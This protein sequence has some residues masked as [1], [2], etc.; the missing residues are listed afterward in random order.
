M[1]ICTAHA[2]LESR[3]DEDSRRWA[4]QALARLAKK[5][6]ALQDAIATHPV[7]EII[8][9][10][11]ESRQQLE[12]KPALKCLANLVSGEGDYVARWAIQAGLL[13]RAL[14]IL[15]TG[16]TKDKKTMLWTLSNI[17]GS[18]EEE[19]RQSVI[20]ESLLMQQVVQLMG[21][22]NCEAVRGEAAWVVT[23][24][25]TCGENNYQRGRFVQEMGPEL[26][27]QLV[28]LLRELPDQ[29]M[30]LIEVMSATVKL[31]DLDQ[32]YPSEFCGD[33]SIAHIFEC[34][35]GFDVLDSLQDHPNEA[36]QNAARDILGTYS[37]EG[38]AEME[39]E[40]VREGGPEQ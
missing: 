16:V 20:E 33:N 7:V 30:V 12:Y 39:N 40:F 29:Q 26:I 23:N 31:L 37:G 25:L 10:S 22:P 24:L 11:L 17:A 34:A 3:S 19:L 6:T 2:I 28:N 14:E 9:S 35:Q 18:P 1:L 15:N 38:F 13:P 5:N 8:M 32:T 36:I 4:I 21:S 27:L